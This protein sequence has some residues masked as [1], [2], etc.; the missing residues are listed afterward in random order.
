[1]PSLF[2]ELASGS[3]PACKV[4]AYLSN[5]AP[6]EQME[7]HAELSKSVSQVGN[8]AVVTALA[9]R[10]VRLTEVSVRRH[11]SRHE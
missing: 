6:S 9:R 2:E 4:C 5:L 1:M 7:W 10:G 8:T 3:A 11:R